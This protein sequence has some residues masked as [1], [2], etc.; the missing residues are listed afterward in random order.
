M[1]KT[2]LLLVFGFALSFDC[3]AQFLDSFFGK[4]KGSSGN[5]ESG[6]SDIVSN[7]FNEVVGSVT[8]GQ[9]LTVD[10]I[11]GTWNYEGTTCALESDEMLAE[12]GSRL[13]TVKVEEKINS[14]LLKV[15]VQKGTSS[16]TFTADGTCTA[17][18]N[19]R[20]FAGT[21]TIGED[22]KSMAFS[23]LLGKL[24]LNSTV[25][26]TANS[27]NISFDANKI[28]GIVKNLSSAV[29][30]YGGSQAASSSSLSSSLELVKNIGTLLEGFNGMRMGVRVSR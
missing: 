17:L 7:L 22:G 6:T 11:S 21:Y 20:S 19:G 27:M 30:Q 13:V 18:V 12:L 15:G 3:N 5:T 14:L 26:Y 23:F 2:I 28:L 9:K 8:G 25:Q 24:T 4:L 10:A 16:L 1:K 29:S